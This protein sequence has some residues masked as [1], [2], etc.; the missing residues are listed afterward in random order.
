MR[1]ILFS[2]IPLAALHLAATARGVGLEPVAVIVPRASR[3]PGGT[4]QHAELL[5]AV[6]DSIDVCYIADRA[7]LV[8]LARA[9]APDVGL[10]AGYPWRLPPEVLGAT[11]L[12]VVNSHPS[13]L[14]RH[15]GP[16][17]LAWAVRE[18]DAE[19]GLTIHLM[20]QEFDTGPVLAQASRP[21]P[22]D[23]TMERL[24]P[25]IAALSEELLPDALGRVLA[26][27]RG[28][29]QASKGA[30]YA[31]PFGED[32]AVLDPARTRAELHRQVRAWAL[33]FD[34]SVAGPRAML[35]GGVVRVL[36]ATPDDPRDDAVPR[37]E[38]ADGPLWLTSVEELPTGK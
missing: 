28:T 6:P 14:P 25:V 34:R 2:T 21:L 5:A 19:L 30:T 24:V 3:F 29:P 31:G 18:A 8:R 36:D 10:C 13:L 22:A 7:G 23:P 15:R 37:L 27:E 4:E 9:Y 26:G 16:F 1:A 32:Y 12:G 35:G 38:T 33:M 17:P 11:R 20:D